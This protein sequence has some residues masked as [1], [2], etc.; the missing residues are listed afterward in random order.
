MIR[1]ALYLSVL[2][3]ALLCAGCATPKKTSEEEERGRVVG[4]QAAQIAKFQ[5]KRQG[6]W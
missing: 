1:N 5:T 2:S 6:G 4:V 3:L